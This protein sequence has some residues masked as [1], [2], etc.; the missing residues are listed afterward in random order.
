MV[1]AGSNV[2]GV[3]NIYNPDIRADAFTINYWLREYEI[4][5]E[6]INIIR[7]KVNL[8]EYKIKECEKDLLECEKNVYRNRQ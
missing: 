4:L 5:T 2:S 3:A 6:E 7:W 1:V 8:N